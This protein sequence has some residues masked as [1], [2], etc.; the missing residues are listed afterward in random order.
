MK[1]ILHSLS[2]FIQSKNASLNRHNRHYEAPGTFEQDRDAG[3]LNIKNDRI[4]WPDFA[5][6]EALQKNPQIKTAVDIG[7]GTG[8]VAASLDPLVDEII[9]I[10]PSFAAID[11]SKRA[12]PQ[13]KYPNI[14]WY[15]GF[16]EDLLPTITL[17]NPT[18]FVTGCVLSHLR[19][20][21]VSQIC[22]SVV[23]VAP[24]ESIFAF[25]EC[26]SENTPLHQ[27][28]WHIRNKSWWQNQFPGWELEFGGT[29][30]EHGDYY[31]GIWGT[32]K[33]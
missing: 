3:Y 26:W 25:C 18:I 6:Q 30:H 15:Q 16:A 8:W 4:N 17:S 7:S 24:A 20:K 2:T 21:E 5:I 32:K 31:M 23:K 22:A 33:V 14:T 29:K 27:H 11:I 28:M 1:K 19:D 10:E 12:Y 9:A 13:V